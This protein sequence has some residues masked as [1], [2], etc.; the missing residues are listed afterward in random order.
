MIKQYLH[1]VPTLIIMAVSLGGLPAL[2]HQ[3]L[4]ERAATQNR[5]AA[6]AAPGAHPLR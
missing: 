5:N 2:A 1:V 6:P 3:A 4:D